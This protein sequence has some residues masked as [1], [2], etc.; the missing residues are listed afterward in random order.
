MLYLP[1][2]QSIRSSGQSLI[3]ARY[4]QVHRLKAEYFSRDTTLSGGVLERIAKLL[5]NSAAFRAA[6]YIL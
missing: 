2:R 4:A 3:Q 1:D 5:N 6:F